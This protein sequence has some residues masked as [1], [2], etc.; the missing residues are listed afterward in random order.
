MDGLMQA[1]KQGKTIADF[2][3]EQQAD[4]VEHYQAI[5]QHAIKTG[6]R[7]MLA[8]ATAAYEPYVGQLARI[9]GKGANMTQMSQQDLTPPAPGV[10][11]ATV[12]G[13]PMYPSKLLGGAM[14]GPGA[15]PKPIS[16]LKP[17]VGMTMT[18]TVKKIYDPIPPKGYKLE[19]LR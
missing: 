16:R 5:T 8:Q 9:P 18:D 14:R 15:Q 1:Q 4:M 6:N 13:M 10:P 19:G 12:A 17:M 2:N 11:P 7:A 3:P